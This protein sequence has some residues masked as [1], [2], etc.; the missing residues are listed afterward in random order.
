MP[1]L[2]NVTLVDRQGSPVTH[3]FTP[4]NIENG[5]GTVVE[6][7]GVPIGN[8]TVTISLRKTPQNRYKAILKGRFPVVQD[9]EINGIVSPV[10]VRTSNVEMS[11]NFEAT[12]SEQERKDVVGMM[13][14][15]LDANET[16]FNDVL[17]K[18]QGV[19]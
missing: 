5:V 12:S 8:N 13:Q 9:Q 14:S 15:A 19:Y 2:S 17:T 10:V 11:F 3:T 6:S 18:L 1:Q 7:S 16:L 4:L